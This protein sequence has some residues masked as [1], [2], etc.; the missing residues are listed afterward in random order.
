M[1]SATA[2]FTESEV[3]DAALEWLEDLGWSVVHG[4]SIAPD[5]PNAERSD[6]SEVILER[7]LLD[8]LDRL[9]PDLPVEAL[10]DAFRKLSRPEGAT[11]ETRN[12]AFSPNAGGRR[13]RRVSKRW[14][15]RARSAGPG[16][17]L[18]EPPPTT[19]G[20]R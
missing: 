3:E 20:W 15:R 14:R 7:R 12:R 11:P 13:D 5:A 17:R 4:P 18:R 16:P 2:A 19:T 6:Y 9:N 1:T 10:D 8:A